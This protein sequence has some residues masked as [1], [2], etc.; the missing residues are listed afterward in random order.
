V[1]LGSV[2]ALK[3]KVEEGTLDSGKKNFFRRSAA[4]GKL[5]VGTIVM[6]PKGPLNLESG[7]E[8]S[9]LLGSRYFL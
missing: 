4:A 1:K 7:R 3:A 5:A 9:C 2:K 6:D 8:L